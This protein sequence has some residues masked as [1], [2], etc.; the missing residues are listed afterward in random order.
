MFYK[1]INRIKLIYHKLIHLQ[2]L[3]A[4][5]LQYKAIIPIQYLILIT[6]LL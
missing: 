6:A 5:V 1:N 3:I 4:I 2:H